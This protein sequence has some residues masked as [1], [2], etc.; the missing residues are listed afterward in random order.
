MF[1]TLTNCF[2]IQHGK[3]FPLQIHDVSAD[4]QLRETMSSETN[5]GH[6]L[7]TIHDQVA[8]VELTSLVGFRF[9]ENT[10]LQGDTTALCERVRGE[11]VGVKAEIVHHLLRHLLVPVVVGALVRAE[12]QV[13]VIHHQLSIGHIQGQ[14]QLPHLGAEVSVQRVLHAARGGLHQHQPNAVG[15]LRAQIVEVATEHAKV[16]HVDPAAMHLLG[17]ADRR[18][19]VHLAIGIRLTPGLGCRT[20]LFGICLEHDVHEL[21]GE[22]LHQRGGQIGGGGLQLGIVLLHG[23]IVDDEPREAVRAESRMIVHHELLA[24]EPVEV[25]VPVARFRLHRWKRAA[26]VQQVEA[27]V[28]CLVTLDVGA[29]VEALRLALE[30]A[31][32]MR[33]QV[34]TTASSAHDLV[35]VLVRRQY[36]AAGISTTVDV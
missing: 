24:K 27:P 1:H 22:A 28:L 34:E 11:M 5:A 13:E 23:R 20:E 12:H 32:V 35:E 2:Q 10:R 33:F 30:H 31:T 3:R 26:K 17:K 4:T 18:K 16:A 15:S 25:S 6:R 7:K 9:E 14:T 29:A 19:L 8:A 36:R 21:F